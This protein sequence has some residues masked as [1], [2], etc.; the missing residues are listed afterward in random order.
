MLKWLQG[1]DEKSTRKG[2]AQTNTKA[3]QPQQNTPE[4]TVA[5]TNNDQLAEHIKIIAT[6]HPEQT[7]QL[8]KHW[9]KD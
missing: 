4:K 9:I 1:K 7:I 8:I 3:K 5:T 6:D 2:K